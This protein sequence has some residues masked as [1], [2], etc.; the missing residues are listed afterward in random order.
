MLLLT[1]GKLLFLVIADLDMVHHKNV[2]QETCSLQRDMA[3]KLHLKGYI[4][5]RFS[6]DM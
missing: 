3:L 5:D 6:F 2:L 4:W 1:Q